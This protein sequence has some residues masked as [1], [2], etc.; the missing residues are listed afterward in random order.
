LVTSP[1]NRGRFL[2]GGNANGP[3]INDPEKAADMIL[4]GAAA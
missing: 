3:T 4:N 2:T 1:E